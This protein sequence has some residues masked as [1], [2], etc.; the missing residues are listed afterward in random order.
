M[1]SQKYTQRLEPPISSRAREPRQL[2]GR[3]TLI[4]FAGAAFQLN[5]LAL[6]LGEH[7]L[8]FKSAVAYVRP[9]LR[10]QVLALS[11]SLQTPCIPMQQFDPPF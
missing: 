11:T 10:S 4:P 6:V 8:F 2:T 1:L 5:E 9:M 7:Y 3:F